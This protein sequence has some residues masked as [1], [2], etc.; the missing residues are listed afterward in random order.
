MIIIGTILSLH[1]YD[2]F[3]KIRQSG[4]QI[5]FIQ[6]IKKEAKKLTESTGL[7]KEILSE[8]KTGT[9]NI[10]MGSLNTIVE[11]IEIYHLDNG[12]YPQSID[13]LVGDYISPKSTILQDK[14]FYYR[15]I[16]S[17]YETGITLPNGEKYII[18]N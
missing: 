7:Y 4:S 6:H 13:I 11:A 16:G 10:K 5:S 18:K 3:R 1:W 2:T 15:K 14:T 9:I 12:Y 8:A 17:N